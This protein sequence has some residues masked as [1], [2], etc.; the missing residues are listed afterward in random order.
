[1]STELAKIEVIASRKTKQFRSP[2]TLY[3]KERNTDKYA[4]NRLK[5]DTVWNDYFIFVACTFSTS[6]TQTSL[7]QGIQLFVKIIR[8]H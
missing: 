6:A 3:S 5:P 8:R 2:I 4:S 7:I 1:M